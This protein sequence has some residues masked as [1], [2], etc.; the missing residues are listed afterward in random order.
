MRTA[1]MKRRALLMI[2]DAEK[3]LKPAQRRLDFIAL[4]LS[5]KKIGLD[6]VIKMCDELV[7]VLKKEQEDDDAKKTYCEKELDTS[8]DTKKALEQAISD[9]TKAIEDAE[10]TIA[11]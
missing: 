2:R 11:T 3:N 8:E 10:E 1:E 9:A 5:G 6:K 4:A 7:V